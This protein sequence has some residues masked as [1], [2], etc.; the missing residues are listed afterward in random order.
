MIGIKRS[1][2]TIDATGKVPGRLAAQICIVLMGKDKPAYKTY[3][4]GGDIV[5]VENVKFMKLNEKKLSRTVLYRHTQ[6]PGGLRKQLAKDLS[7]EQLLRRAIYSMLPKNKLRA[8]M[9]KRLTIR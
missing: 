1:T 4:D 3:I 5:A 7:P 2:K 6:H 8:R 9:L